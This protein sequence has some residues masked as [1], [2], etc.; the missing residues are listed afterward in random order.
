MD[1]IQQNVK[2]IPIKKTPVKKN[3]TKKTTKKNKKRKKEEEEMLM[4]GGPSNFELCQ[5]NVDLFKRLVPNITINF[6]KSIQSQMPQNN[7][8]NN[9]NIESIKNVDH[10]QQFVNVNNNNNHQGVNIIDPSNINIIKKQKLP[11]PNIPPQNINN[12]PH[13]NIPHQIINIPNSPMMPINYLMKN[14]NTPNSQNINISPKIVQN[15]IPLKNPNT[16]TTYIQNII[17]TPQ[18]IQEKNIHPPPHTSSIPQFP[19]KQIP[20]HPIKQQIKIPQH[21]VKG[22][23]ISHLAQQILPNDQIL[24]KL[25]VELSITSLTFPLLIKCLNYLDLKNILETRLVNKLFHRASMECSV[26]EKLHLDTLPT[27]LVNSVE[28]NREFIWN[29]LCMW[30]LK[31]VT[32]IYFRSEMVDLSIIFSNYVK[33]LSMVLG[34]NNVSTCI[35]PNV[36]EVVEVKGGSNENT[37]NFQSILRCIDL[38]KIEKLK[39]H[40]GISLDTL[41]KMT[42]VFSSLKSL[43]VSMIGDITNFYDILYNQSNL[44]HIH[45]G[46]NVQLEP[47]KM[48]RMT[49]LES[50]TWYWDGKINELYSL[51]NLGSLKCVHLHFNE[52]PDQN[53]DRVMLVTPYYLSNL[54]KLH[55]INEGEYLKY[56]LSIESPNLKQLRIINSTAYQKWKNLFSKTNDLLDISNIDVVQE[57][58]NEKNMRQY[59]DSCFKTIQMMNCPN[60][61][62]LLICSVVFTDAMLELVLSKCKFLT[63]I[64]LQ[65]TFNEKVHIHSEHLKV[66]KLESLSR[67]NFLSLEC[68]SLY[69]L[70]FYGKFHNSFHLGITSWAL[71]QFVFNLNENEKG[72]IK[73]NS[74]SHIYGNNNN[75]SNDQLGGESIFA[76]VFNE[77]NENTV[78]HINLNCPNLVE[79]ACKSNN[80]ELDQLYSLVFQGNINNIKKIFLNLGKNVWREKISKKF[81]FTYPS[82]SSASFS[83]LLPPN[84]VNN[85]KN[86]DLS[87]FKFPLKM[88]SLINLHL[89][90]FQIKQ[91]WIQ[92]NFYNNFKLTE[93][94]L[95]NIYIDTVTLLFVKEIFGSLRVLKLRRLTNTHSLSIRLPTLKH[96]TVSDC[97]LF[98][99]FNQFECDSL[100]TFIF[101][102]CPS[103]ENFEVSKWKSLPSLKIFALGGVRLSLFSV[104]MFPSIFSSLKYI[105]YFPLLTR[106]QNDLDSQAFFETLLSLNKNY[107][108]TFSELIEDWLT[109]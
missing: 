14:P 38:S 21:P 63:E 68:P 6:E 73:S 94:N 80:L 50:M 10:N 60:L 41:E 46:G 36:T 29:K 87:I 39:L 75:N 18:L 90:N 79:F 106:E 86:E 108:I 52:F 83:C 16:P 17:S 1:N 91:K 98:K 42:G 109:C 61:T 59:Q 53:T 74:N 20:Q 48:I 40:L 105:H 104:E 88:E 82:V 62:R 15:M 19:T 70:K 28:Y 22:N 4:V 54:T 11:T 7:I 33:R 103:T 92:Q 30:P 8:P 32:K 3:P 99:T 5:R 25:H 76:H 26:W 45:F 56:P 47:S 24:R 43:R 78:N 89:S 93:L 31:R 101:Y 37:I 77:N 13:Q 27:M 55:L 57:Q 64:D 67:L 84:E 100:E 2:K 44:L 49:K 34:N 71:R 95:D 85:I 9:E 58:E 102:N 23:Y 72:R 107:F 12:I 96:L 65:Y 66:F 81:T 97:H 35:F 51:A 69:S